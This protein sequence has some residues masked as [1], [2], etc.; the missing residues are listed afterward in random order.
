MAAPSGGET[1]RAIKFDRIEVD[2][3][4]G[5]LRVTT[6]PAFDLGNPSRVVIGYDP[7]GRGLFF[8]FT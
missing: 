5:G 1:E 6:D 4:D 8:R 2:V 3:H 7:R